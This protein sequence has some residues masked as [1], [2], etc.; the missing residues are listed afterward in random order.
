MPF[1]TPARLSIRESLKIFATIQSFIAKSRIGFRN[2]PLSFENACAK[3][4]GKDKTPTSC[5]D[6]VENLAGLMLAKR[7]IHFSTLSH[8]VGGSSFDQVT[9]HTNIVCYYVLEKIK[10]VIEYLNTSKYTAGMVNVL[11]LPMLE[12]WHDKIGVYS[13]K[14][15]SSNL[16]EFRH[17]VLSKD[18]PSS[19]PRIF[20]C[21]A[22]WLTPTFSTLPSEADPLSDFHD[23][24]GEHV[25]AV[26]KHSNTNY[27]LISG[28]KLLES[29]RATQPPMDLDGWQHSTNE[30]SNR[31]GFDRSLCK[32]LLDRLGCFV[33]GQEFKADNWFA[34]FHAQ[35]PQTKDKVWPS[36]L[37]TELQDSAIRGYGE[38]EHAKEVEIL[39]R[40]DK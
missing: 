7:D 31:K 3:N 6:T 36:F 34:L 30:Y 13:R 23:I 21:S 26:V 15:A 2:S 24:M 32:N 20:F 40:N 39:M 19:L 29:E 25:F 18:S 10:V 17:T 16:A 27:Q 4:L 12:Y 35:Y 28:Y 37:V 38:R 22:T 1:A 9:G 33:G 5:G 8:V 14:N 11:S